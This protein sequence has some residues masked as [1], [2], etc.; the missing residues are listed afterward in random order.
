MKHGR[1]SEAIVRATASARMV[2]VVGIE[3]CEDG[4]RVPKHAAG[5][6]SR[7]A[8]LS[9]A[10]GFW[11]P[12][13]PP[14]ASRKIGWSR[15][16]GG[17][18]REAPP[19]RERAKADARTSRRPPCRTLDSVPRWIIRQTVERDTPRARPATSTETRSDPILDG[20]FD[21]FN[22]HRQRQALFPPDLK[23]FANRGS[24]V[25]QRRSPGRALTDA[26]RNLR[27]FGDEATIF[28]L[29]DCHGKNSFA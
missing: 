27:T 21:L 16:N 13:R 20:D 14:P 12:P 19:I 1:R 25:F 23:T 5:H 22:I 7:M 26:A 29:D 17:I 6:R 28:I 15:V 2:G 9:R 3:Q 4:A 11:P 18:G 8:C 10:P 24:D